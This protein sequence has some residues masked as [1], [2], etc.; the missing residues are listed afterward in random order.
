[1]LSVSPQDTP[2]PLFHQYMLGSIAPRPIAFAST[3]DENGQ[4]N[5][6][7]FSFFNAFGSNPPIV[8]FS[9]ARSGREGT[10]K[11]SFNNIKKV[12]EVVINVVSYNMVQQ[13]SLSSAEYPKEVNEFTKAGFTAIPSVKV[14]PF[15]VKESPV[16]IECKVLEVKEMGDKGGAAN[17]I[18]CEIL[19][20]HISDDILNT[21]KKIDPNK[22]DLVGRM[23]GNWYC[24][25]SG[26][27]L[28]ELAQ[29]VRNLGIGIDAL[30]E[31]IRHSKL[32]S[33]NDLGK[34]GNVAKLPSEAEV[35][36]Y[37][38]AKKFNTAEELHVEA[39]KLLDA[40]NIEE[41]WKLLLSWAK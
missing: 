34:L 16:Q 8:V 24:R 10:T 11:H 40:N 5:L 15:R 28:F 13:A 25:A 20:M 3:I 7:P 32:L 9:P 12:P 29:P 17:L 4:P 6:S 18:I 36:E 1:M 39:K 19:L 2:Q 30:P 14:K 41:A 21:E 35:K 33:G 22:I 31:N 27:N 26:S 23:G 37:K 38:A